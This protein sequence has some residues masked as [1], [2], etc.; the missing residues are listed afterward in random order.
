NKW[1]GAWISGMVLPAQDRNLGNLAVTEVTVNS[2]NEQDLTCQKYEIITHDKAHLDTFEVQHTSQISSEPK[3]QKYIINFLGNNGCY[4]ELI[5]EM[6][7]DARDLQANVVGF[8]LRGVGQSTGK[9]TSK[10]DIVI[11]GVAQ[12]Q[13]LL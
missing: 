3:Y 1:L 5:S 6:K 9:V 11:D 2:Y 10:Q 13:R 12:V 4:E 8:N 7:E